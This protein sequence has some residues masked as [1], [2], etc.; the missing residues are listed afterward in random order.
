MCCAVRD[1][2][3]MLMTMCLGV[4]VGP[5]LTVVLLTTMMV[6]MMTIIVMIMMTMM[7]VVVMIKLVRLMGREL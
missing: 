7:M 3:R 4:V 1:V 2:P 5:M 6:M